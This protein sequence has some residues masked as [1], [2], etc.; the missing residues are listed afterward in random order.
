M[1][2]RH[3]VTID[4]K[5]IKAVDIRC[6]CGSLISIRLPKMNLAEHLSCPG[7]NT[8]FW[9]AQEDGSPHPKVQALVRNLSNWQQVERV[10][11]TLEFSL[12]SLDRA[13]SEKGS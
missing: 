12:D 3:V 2:P 6:N 7:C 9:Y 1:T 4:F 11:F 8:M 5:E 10:P 13:S